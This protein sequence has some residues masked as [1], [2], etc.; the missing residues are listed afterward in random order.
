MAPAGPARGSKGESIS[1]PL[2]ASRATFLAFVVSWP[3]LLL[4]QNKQC[5]IL[6]HCHISFFFCSHSS[7]VS[8]YRILVITFKAHPYHLGQSVHIKILNLIPSTKCPLLYKITFTASRDW[9]LY[10][11]GGSYLAY[12]NTES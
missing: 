11:S 1:L 4:L 9:D 7:P 12:D 3:F 6:L 10:I 8:L 5:G 2:P